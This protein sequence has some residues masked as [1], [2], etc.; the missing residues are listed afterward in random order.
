[1]RQFNINKAEGFS[2]LMT[3]LL[4]VALTVVGLAV[5]RSGIITE[6]QAINIQEKSVT[7][8]AAQS[9]NNAVVDTM[10]NSINVITEA[11]DN[12]TNVSNNYRNHNQDYS[13]C[14]DE[15]GKV[16]ETCATQF[17]SGLVANSRVYYRGCATAN[18]C[19][20]YSAGLD[21]QISCHVIELKGKGFFDT[22]SDGNADATESQTDIN[23][24][25]TRAAQSCT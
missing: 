23:Q 13:V 6:K 20:G 4:F 11:M 25:A 8:H 14:I 17:E 10:V 5:M 19:Q 9:A 2:L 18:L 1:M 15:K 12:V 16:L 22:D 24:W 7:F 3:M 21:S